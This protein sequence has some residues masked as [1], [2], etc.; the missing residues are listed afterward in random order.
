MVLSRRLVPYGGP[1]TPSLWRP[2]AEAA[3]LVSHPR[4]KIDIK[5]HDM[6]T[7]SPGA[8]LNDEV[9]NLSISLLQER[10]KRWREAGAAAPTCHY[11]SS[12]FL[13]KMFKDSGKYNYNEVR[14]WTMPLRLKNAG[15]LSASV[16]DC[17]RIIIPANQGNT[18]WVC[19]MADLKNKKFVLFDSLGVSDERRQHR[20]GLAHRSPILTQG[21]DKKCLENLAQYVKD[22]YKNKK[23]EEV[24]CFRS[25]TARRPRILT[26]ALG[27]IAEG[28]RAELAAGVPQ[29]H[30][31]PGQRLRLRHVHHPVRRVLRK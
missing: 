15:Q 30:P 3:L 11:F 24:R 25:V 8:W 9:I 29:G 12:F 22:E 5:G 19:A 2:A 18:H 28:R 10:D 17:D 20:R 4:S 1:L 27:R 6:R 16:L 26:P 21:E 13:N 7:L 23:D 31:A 14:R